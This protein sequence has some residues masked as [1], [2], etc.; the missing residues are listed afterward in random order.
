MD[1]IR[2]IK[3]GYIHK[4]I[5]FYLKKALDNENAFKIGQKNKKMQD[6]YNVLKELL[7]K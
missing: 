5:N 2:Y 4:K 7:K 1:C 6:K 3:E